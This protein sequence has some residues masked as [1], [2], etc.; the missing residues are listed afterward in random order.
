MQCYSRGN[1]KVKILSLHRQ[2]NK[3]DALHHYDFAVD[4]HFR[5]RPDFRG[6]LRRQSFA[7]KLVNERWYSRRRENYVAHS[8]YISV[9]FMTQLTLSAAFGWLSAI[10]LQTRQR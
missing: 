8:G 1:K 7:V 5:H 3:L 4:L 9:C 10:D 2:T 6:L